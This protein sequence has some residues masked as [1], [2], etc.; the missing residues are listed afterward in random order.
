MSK[1]KASYKQA[2]LDELF[3]DAAPPS[4]DDVSVTNDG[5]RLDSAQA[6]IAFFE[7]MKAERAESPGAG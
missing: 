3:A 2:E 6:V 1:L 4:D 7:E 5:R